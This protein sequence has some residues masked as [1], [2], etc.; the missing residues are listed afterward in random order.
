MK[1]SRLIGIIYGML[2]SHR[3][4]TRPV[5]LATL[6][7]LGVACSTQDGGP[8]A[9]ATQENG[10]EAPQLSSTSNT[11][12]RQL[13]AE[14]YRIF[15]ESERSKPIY[16]RMKLAWDR[17]HRNNPSVRRNNSPFPMCDPL[18]YVGETKIIGSEGGELS[19]GPHKLIIPRGALTAS[20]V[21]TG[22]MPVDTLVSV[23][24]S[25]HGLTFRKQVTLELSYKHCY[26]PVNYVYRMAYIDDNNRI[27]EFPLSVDYK[28]DG[29]VWGYLK[30]FSRYAVA[31]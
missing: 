25:P 26:L 5:V 17:F 23:K 24:V 15:L 21:I 16:D 12:N 27:L 4:Q 20:T 18:Q 19:I 9:P 6:L 29:E 1:M 22:E 28:K 30:H 31:Y 14:K 2:K 3:R 11:L 7:L 13:E 10:W 8:T